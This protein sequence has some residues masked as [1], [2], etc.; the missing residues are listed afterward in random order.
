MASGANNPQQSSFKCRKCRRFLFNEDSILRSTSAKDSDLTTTYHQRSGASGASL[1]ISED[2]TPSWIKTAIEESQW[3][4]GKLACPKCRGRLGSFDFLTPSIRH[5]QDHQGPW[6]SVHI[7]GSRVDHELPQSQLAKL[8]GGVRDQDPQVKGQASPTKSKDSYE[9]SVVGLLPNEDGTLPVGSWY[10]DTHELDSRSSKVSEVDKDELESVS[11]L[12]TSTKTSLSSV[13]PKVRNQLRFRPGYKNT[14]HSKTKSHASNATSVQESQS[15][16]CTSMRNGP[17]TE[18]CSTDYFNRI[19]AEEVLDAD[20]ESNSSHSNLINSSKLSRN[21]Q[22]TSISIPPNSRQTALRSTSEDSSSDQTVPRQLSIVDQNTLG[23]GS[24]SEEENM[25]QSHVVVGTS[26]APLTWK[27]FLD[28]LLLELEREPS[29]LRAE[30][31]VNQLVEDFDTDSQQEASASSDN[32]F[33]GTGAQDTEG[34]SAYLQ[35][36]ILRAQKK[37]KNRRKNERRKLRRRERWQEEKTMEDHELLIEEQNL[38]CD[39][40]KIMSLLS[41]CDSG[42]SLREATTCPVCLDL[43]LYPNVC[44]PC[45]HV[46]CEPCLR[47]LAQA[48]QSPRTPC[49]LCRT[50]IQHV[51]AHETLTT[52]IQEAFPRMIAL[53]KQNERKTLNKSYPL[54]GDALNTPMSTWF[55]HMLRGHTRRHITMGLHHSGLRGRQEFGVMWQIGAACLLMTTLVGMTGVFLFSIM[56][57]S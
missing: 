27:D 42:M 50:V 10:L 40:A 41:V 12:P 18:T 9:K 32:D 39:S 20:T 29:P 31:D 44:I 49:P 2:A 34:T 8:R 36:A 46:F 22:A 1:Y 53:R 19:P 6:S 25:S 30:N 52:A 56:L 48:V 23:S 17:L 51:K 14:E 54:P 43:Y 7:I 3:T 5:H 38:D 47:Q 21:S 28:E 26:S 11:I 24:E 45:Q 55:N 16:S 57:Y 33:Q 13:E 37:E 35:R 15:G 4:R